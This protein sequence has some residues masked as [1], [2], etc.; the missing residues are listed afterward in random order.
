VSVWLRLHANALGEA[1]GR[2]ARQPLASG[3]AIV[4]LGIAI[5]LPVIA[6]VALRSIGAIAAGLD[7]EPHVNVYLALSATDEDVRKVESALRAHPDA[8]RVRFVSREQALAELK[9]TTHL[10][11]VL[12]A[13]QGNPLP[14]AFTVRVR[15]TEPERVAALRSEWAKLPQVEQ[16]QADFE[17]SRRLAGWAGFARRALGVGWV[18]LGA[19]VAFIVGHLIRL[20]VVT[21][22]QEIEVSQLIGATAADVRRPFLYHGLLQGLLAGAAAV[23]LAAGLAAWAALELQALT[24]SYAL[25]FKVI[26]PNFTEW[27]GVLGAAALLGLAGAWVAVSQEL[28][29][30]ATGR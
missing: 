15:T 20:Q 25:E 13:L 18:L 6:A 10:A 23:G 2:L 1:L 28:R 11:E 9:Q 4:V 5:A 29:R 3:V 14:H 24:N 7:A 19:A 26:F 27:L 16:V 21:R 17:W 12:A 8:A 30:F 22:R